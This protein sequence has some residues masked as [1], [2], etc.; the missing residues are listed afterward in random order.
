MKGLCFSMIYVGAAVLANLAIWYFGPVAVGPVA[1]FAIGCDL[2]IRDSLHEMWH[3]KWL[4]PKMALLILIGSVATVMSCRDSSRIA[5]ASFLAFM[6]AGFGDALAYSCLY[7]QARIIKMNGSNVVGS[8]I[9]S[10]VF[11]TVAFGAWMPGVMILQFIAKIAGGAIWSWVLTRR[12]IS[13]DRFIVES[14][15]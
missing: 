10:V 11:P 9:D 4:W 14:N 12:W 15:R 5:A 8:A 13:E 2:S 7:R 1:F 6:A 3:G